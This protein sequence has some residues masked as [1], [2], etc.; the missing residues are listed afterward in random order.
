MAGLAEC[1]LPPLLVGP[2]SPAVSGS[3]EGSSTGR[4]SCDAPVDSR[5]ASLIAGDDVGCLPALASSGLTA[6]DAR[7]IDLPVPVKGA[8][9]CFLKLEAF[10]LAPAASLPAASTPA[11]IPSAVAAAAS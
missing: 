5:A 1:S 6:D 7:L 10:L 3:R 2:S 8:C 4:N 11:T 9:C